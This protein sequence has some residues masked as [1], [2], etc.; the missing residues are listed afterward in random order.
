MKINYTKV[1]L[2]VCIIVSDNL[3]KRLNVQFPIEF[4]RSILFVAAASYFGDQIKLAR[5][6]RQLKKSQIAA[7]NTVS[8]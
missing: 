5:E 2:A 4:Y 1:G 8:L 3:L 6:R 7:S